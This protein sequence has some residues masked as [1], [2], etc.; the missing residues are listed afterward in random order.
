MSNDTPTDTEEIDWRALT[1]ETF[2]E[3]VQE[4]ERYEEYLEFME[5]KWEPYRDWYLSNIAQFPQANE[6]PNPRQFIEALVKFGNNL[7]PILDAKIAVDQTQEYFGVSEEKAIDLLKLTRMKN[8][9]TEGDMVSNMA[10]LFSEI[11]EKLK[12]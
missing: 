5:E 12:D 1:V 6:E 3:E 2:G 4:H 10:N 8:E 11:G 7:T 9:G